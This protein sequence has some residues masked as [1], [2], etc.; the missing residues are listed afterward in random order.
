GGTALD[1]ASL[2]NEGLNIILPWDRLFLYNL[3]IQSKTETYN[4]ISSDG[5]NL[6]ATINI[7]FR[8]R[9]EFIPQLHQSIGPDYVNLLGPEVASRMREV[10][11]QYTAEQVYSTERQKIQEEIKNRVID[12]LGERFLERDGAMS[13]HVPIRDIGVLYDTLLHEIRLPTEVVTAINRK[14]EQ[15]YV[16]QEFIYR[17]DRERRESVRKKIE[18]EGIRD[19]QQTVSQG[20]SESYLRW[21]GIEATLEL[22]KSNNAKV[23]IIGS[24]RDGLP[25]ILGNVDGPA[26]VGGGAQPAAAGDGSAPPDD[27]AP[28]GPASPVDRAAPPGPGPA[29]KSK[30]DNRTQLPAVDRGFDSFLTWLRGRSPAEPAAGASPQASD[31]PGR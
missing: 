3:R 4:A 12:K 31:S 6:S 11:S 9:R 13:Y 10:I 27:K 14:A 16:A 15:Y 25:I 18:A 1:P 23:V 26:A 30:S 21:R 22:A 8:L 17:V 19:F 5:V 24:G 29:G 28:G 2:R 20:I 7:R